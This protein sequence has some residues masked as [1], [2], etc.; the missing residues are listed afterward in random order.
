MEP[1]TLGSTITTTSGLSFFN[2]IRWSTSLPSTLV[3][4]FDALLHG[5][6]RPLHRGD[7][8][9]IQGV[10]SS[11][12]TSLMIKIAVNHLLPRQ[13]DVRIDR[14]VIR[15]PVGG[16]EERVV[17]F[18]CT[19]STGFE[20]EILKIGKILRFHLVQ[21]INSYRRPKGIGAPQEEELDELVRGC[22]E[23]LE[24]FSPT[25]TI[26]LATTIQSLEE[27]YTKSSSSTSGEELG[28]VMIDGMTE[29]A[30][31]DQ[32]ERETHHQRSS[33]SSTPFVSPLKLF[34]ASISH[35]RRTLSPLI[36]IS[37]WVL[38]PTQPLSNPSQ[39][40]LPFYRPHFNPPLYP[41]LRNP[42]ISTSTVVTKEK[43]EED[44]PFAPVYY[45]ASSTS[46]SPLFPIH[47]HVTLH[48]SPR[49]VFRKGISFA[50]VLK[51]GG[52]RLEKGKGTKVMTEGIV[53]VLRE[54]GGRE[55]GSW[56]MEIGEDEIIA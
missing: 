11:G 7:V 16:K 37:Q 1:S 32:F 38:R 51:E 53:C 30:W 28:C 36:F 18:N 46:S 56:E 35:L 48:P 55:I 14:Q 27:W 41:S 4:G 54:R 44:D 10:T 17:W 21:A 6:A 2:S 45:P 42:P 12:K 40:N 23:R 9:E 39:Q 49:P 13:V 5:S 22:L 50:S 19:A 52:P 47:F 31:T 20:K 8:T 24:V 29:F 26:Q 33:S 43:E 3:D 34:S 25:S 15:V